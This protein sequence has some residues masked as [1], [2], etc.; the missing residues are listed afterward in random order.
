MTGYGKVELTLD[1]SSVTIEIKSLNSKQIDTNVK[2]SSIYR[3]KEI[4]LRN[5]ISE[6]QEPR[7]Y[8]VCVLAARFESTA[9]LHNFLP[10]HPRQNWWGNTVGGA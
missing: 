6:K 1:N 3:E 10:S 8:N 2:M 7:K 9:G 4:E 5:I